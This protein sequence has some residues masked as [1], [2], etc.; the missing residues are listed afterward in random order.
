MQ[1]WDGVSGARIEFNWLGQKEQG[2]IAWMSEN[3]NLV[4][5]LLARIHESGGVSVFDN[6]RVESIKA[7]PEPE[8]ETSLNISTWPH[9]TL[10]NNQ[11]LAA[12]ILI[13]AD[14]ANSPVRTFAGIPANGWDYGRNAVV[15]TLKLDHEPDRYRTAFQRF[16][17]TGP[18]ALLPLPGPYMTLVWS[19]LPHRAALLKSLSSAD[20]LAMVNAAFRLSITDLDYMHNQPSGQADEFSW[21][22][23][24]VPQQRED[25][26]VP[27]RVVDV[28]E[29]SIAA[30]PL[31]F[32]HADSY[33]GPR[34]ALIGDAA[35]IVHPQA[36]QGLNMGL[37]D[38]EA[39]AKTL[40]YAVRHGQDIGDQLSLESY[41]A[42]QYEPNHRLMGVIDKLHKLYAYESGPVVGLRSIG[43]EAV[44]AIEPLKEF[45]MRQASGTR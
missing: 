4:K 21:R 8:D 37:S 39:L 45:M 35:H 6:T 33:V 14:G 36:G 22:E 40:D 15:A 20:F 5:A 41:N 29:D 30:F 9:V 16:L 27:G 42:A 19:T 13:G 26:E 31:R 28:Q 12:R 23:R 38:S 25:I 44:N 34:V 18:I 3:S 17:P 24:H 43:L 32:R 7:G 11:T 1:V 10:S 2:T